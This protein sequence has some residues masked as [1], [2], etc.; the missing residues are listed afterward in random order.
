[1]ESVDSNISHLNNYVQIP[2]VI[3]TALQITKNIMDGLSGAHPILKASWIVLTILY[4]ATQKVEFQ[5][6]A[7]RE[8][9]E[10]LREILAVADAHRNLLLVEGTEN[11]IDEIGRMSLKVSSLVYEYAR[12]NFALRAAKIQLSDELKTRILECQRSCVDLKDRFDRRIAMETNNVAQEIKDSNEEMKRTLATVKDHQLAKD[13]WKWLDAPDSSPNYH[14]ALERHQEDTFAWF[15]DGKYYNEFRNNA[16]FLWIK[17]TAGCGKTVLCST[18]IRKIEA[19]RKEN[20]KSLHEKLIR[21]LIRQLSAQCDGVPAVLV[22]LYGQG[23]QQPSIR[24]L[25]GVLRHIVESL[26]TVYIIIDSLDECIERNRMLPWIEQIIFEKHDNL[27][28]IIA[29]RL[30][31]DISDTFER[32]DV[33]FIDLASKADEDIALYLDKELPLL[34]NWQFWDNE[35]QRE[36]QS[37]LRKGAQGMFR[38]V[39]LQIAELQ[40]CPTRFAVMKQLRSLPKGLY[41]TYDRILSRIDEGDSTDTKIF[42]RLL[43]FSIRP[44]YLNEI[45]AAAAVQFTDQNEPQ[46]MPSYQYWDEDD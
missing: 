34:K 14:A 46:F 45:A 7:V 28:L 41:E 11:V 26:R 43:S 38:W 3:A 18:I 6:D 15:L 27:H 8:L 40:K 32:P 13:M 29:S 5:D 2:A 22:D 37:V 31:R 12:S 33:P 24:S 35:T 1:M 10:Q 9:A 20:P 16:G 42:L 39:A 36:V 25:E 17:A 4:N 30:E 19:L 23:H 21:S 44:M